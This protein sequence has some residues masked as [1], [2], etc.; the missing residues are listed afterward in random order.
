MINI[1]CFCS[2]DKTSSI[3]NQHHTTHT[4]ETP[5]IATFNSGKKRVIHHVISDD[6]HEISGDIPMWGCSPAKKTRSDRI[7]GG[8]LSVSH[9]QSFDHSR[10]SMGR[11]EFVPTVLGTDSERTS[12]RR[13]NAQLNGLGP[14]V[15]E[16]VPCSE[17]LRGLKTVPSPV[18]PHLLI[19]LPIT[20]PRRE[21]IDL[22]L[23]DA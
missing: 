2:T 13:Y 8:S 19:T 15:N 20:T 14:A 18:R 4:T 3:Y 9:T 17:H 16:I 21:V 23:A 6:D 7:S 22:T 12:R 10:P 1:V 11:K 5:H